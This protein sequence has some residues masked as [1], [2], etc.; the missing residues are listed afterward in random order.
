M[1][2]GRGGSKLMPSFWSVGTGLCSSLGT[3]RHTFQVLAQTMTRGKKVSEDLCWAIVRMLAVLPMG[4]TVA[5]SGISE[6]QVRRISKL[7]EE[8]GNPYAEPAQKSGRRSH[9]MGAEVE[10]SYLRFS[11]PFHC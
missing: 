1:H 8:T 5:I 3:T 9:L 7:F 11:L 6:R 4:M 2:F 10:V